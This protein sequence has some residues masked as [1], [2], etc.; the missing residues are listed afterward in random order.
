MNI[1]SKP[2][3][4]SILALIVI[5]I[6]SVV[7]TFYPLARDEMHPKLDGLTDYTA[8]ELAGRDIYQREGCLTCHSQTVRVLKSD[9]LRYG[10]YSKGG[11]SFYERPALWGSRRMGPDLARIGGKYSD[12]WHIQ[13]FEN[14]RKFAHKSNMPHYKW[15][16]HNELDAVAIAKHL[17][18]LGNTN[19]VELEGKT[20]LDALVAYMQKLGSA[21][22]RLQ[23][24]TVTEADFQA[25]GNPA[26]GKEG[27]VKQGKRLYRE[28]CS[29]C[30]GKHGEGNVGMPLQGYNEYMDE[31][32]AF[33]TISNGLEGYMPQFIN[34]M[35]LS[36]VG[37]L[38]EYVATLE[39][40]EEDDD[41]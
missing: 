8:L 29:G 19:P 17:A 3:L 9:V 30:H 37:S 20:E 24:V 1:Y 25:H 35:T 27:A 36:Q 21:V 10:D 34:V 23:L 15:L 2:I 5:L 28:N 38:V 11:E 39:E 13:H 26:K 4:F 31:M 7:T 33:L 16:K 40:G 18:V 12:E 32:T 22:D 6:G 41:E 14:P